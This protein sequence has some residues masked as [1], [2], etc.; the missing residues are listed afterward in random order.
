[1]TLVWLIEA[2][3]FRTLGVKQATDN[4]EPSVGSGDKR[5]DAVKTEAVVW[6]SGARAVWKLKGGNDR[7]ALALQG[8]STSCGAQMMLKCF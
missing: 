3:H 2:N 6:D 8:I 1:M 4:L 7:T 5:C